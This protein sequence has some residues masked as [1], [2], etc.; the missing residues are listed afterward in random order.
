MSGEKSIEPGEFP[1]EFQLS[2]AFGIADD[3]VSEHEQSGLL[4][5]EPDESGEVVVR[6]RV[7][8]EETGVKSSVSLS[9]DA[10]RRAADSLRQAAVVLEAE[11]FSG[12]EGDDA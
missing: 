3:P 10:A 7:D 1:R 9:P 12:G 6:I 8:G 2:G 11:Q 4:R 5:I